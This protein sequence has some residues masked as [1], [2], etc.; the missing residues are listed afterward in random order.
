MIVRLV[1][2][3]L[4]HT[5]GRTDRQT[6]LQMDLSKP[7]LGFRS[8]ANASKICCGSRMEMIRVLKKA[9]CAGPKSRK[10]GFEPTTP[11]FAKSETSPHHTATE[12]G[13]NCGLVMKLFNF[14]LVRQFVCIEVIK[15]VAVYVSVL[16]SYSIAR[17]VKRLFVYLF[18]LVTECFA[19]NLI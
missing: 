19:G 17:E 1:G 15:F 9:V 14:N 18:T 8:F 12:I 7:I 13:K 11:V 3:D 2:A 10:I 4:F 6:D 16:F 5:D